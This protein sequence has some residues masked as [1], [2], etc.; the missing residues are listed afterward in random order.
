MKIGDIVEV[1]GCFTKNKYIAGRS[2]R[3]IEKILGFHPGRFAQGITV[4]SFKKL[5][6]LQQF[7]LAGYSNVATH[8]FKT[9]ADLNIERLKAEA[10]A[11][12][13][14]T[15]LERLVKVLPAVAHSS[16]MEPDIQYP[17]GQG[18]PQWIANV[19]LPAEV[20]GLITHYPNGIY[21]TP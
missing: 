12:W 11:T 8:R 5:P 9:P 3:E 2:L 4:V 18:A 14:I 7:H 6:T 16:Q 17:H 20:I 21:A 1:S 13:S 10:L 19:R 15:G